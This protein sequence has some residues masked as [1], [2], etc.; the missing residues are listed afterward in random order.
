V[1]APV[2]GC[3]NF[4]HHAV[5]YEYASG[6]KLFSFCRQQAGCRGDVSDYIMG[7]KGRA[8]LMKHAI[9]GENKWH[10]RGDRV[11]I[12]HEEHKAL[13]ASIRSGQPINNGLYMTRSTMVAIL[14]RMATYTG[15]EITWEQAINSTEKLG[16]EKYE[17][18]SLPV[19][20]VAM[21]GITQFS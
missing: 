2:E 4:D 7:T 13:F 16:P 21:P 19:A 14:G 12:Y 6:V 18:G 8:A 17:W 10:Y 20:P 15:Q 9:E 5:V 1:R 11:N 3:N